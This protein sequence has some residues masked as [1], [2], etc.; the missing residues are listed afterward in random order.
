M[1]SIPDQWSRCPALAIM[2]SHTYWSLVAFSHP[3]TLLVHSTSFL[4]AVFSCCVFLWSLQLTQDVP[5]SLFS[6]NILKR[7]HGIYTLVLCFVRLFYTNVADDGMC[8]IC[9]GHL[10]YERLS[11]AYDFMLDTEYSVQ[12]YP[13]PWYTWF[14][15]L[16]IN[17]KRVKSVSPG[18]LQSK[19]NRVQSKQHLAM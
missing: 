8:V 14:H 12:H 13:T 9:K 10:Y 11:F 1:S 7:L 3:A 6:L 2:S 18:S 17:V 4:L 19:I 15:K 16:S 5:V